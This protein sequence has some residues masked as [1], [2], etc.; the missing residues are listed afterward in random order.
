VEAHAPSW[1]SLLGILLDDEG[2]R[3]GESRGRMDG[4]RDVDITSGVPIL[5]DDSE[6]YCDEVDE[7]D[8]KGVINTLTGG[9]RSCLVIEDRHIQC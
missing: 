7:I 4:D 2:A 6:S 8:L 3:L 1:W 9:K 5:E